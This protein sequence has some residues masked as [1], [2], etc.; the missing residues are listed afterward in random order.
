LKAL[1]KDVMRS[2]LFFIPH[3]IGGIPLFGF[4]I[5][6]GLLVA[7]LIGWI[8]WCLVRKRPASD[9]LGTLPLFAIAAAIVIFVLPGVEQRWPDGTPIGLPIRGY[10]VMV[11]LGLLSGVGLTVLRARQ[12]GIAADNVIGLGFWMM[13][14]G[15]LGARAFYVIQ[16]WEEFDTWGKVFQLTEGGLVIYGGVLGGLIAGAVYCTK[17]RLKIPAMADLITPGFLLG[18]AFGRVGCLLHGCCYGG[19]CA[20]D[21]PS[22]QFAHGSVPYQAQ[23]ATGRL[24]GITT[25][26]RQ[27]PSRIL[28]V[29][30]ESAAA[31]HGIAAGQQLEGVLLDGLPAQKGSNPTA[32][33]QLYVQ[34]I[35]DG[36][37]Y[38]FFPS[39]LPVVSL[40]THPSQVYSAINALL[41]CA[42]LW[43]LQPL[44][45]RDGITF[46]A[47]IALYAV[48]RFVLE[49][50]RSDEAGQ[51]GTSLTIAQ[52]IAVISIGLA[53]AGLIALSRRPPGRC[54]RWEAAAS[55]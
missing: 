48:S 6:M 9:W 28:A 37:K 55:Y 22:L 23:I 49:G 7:A 8:L 29:E 54:W 44:P 40:P 3:E 14:T 30:P 39:A 34:A 5:A 52:W 35:V 24:L 50:V 16:K 45:M 38:D 42:L 10:G 15:I 18:L 31:R 41:L 13:F 2:T 46:L 27:L 20:A 19:V 12:L 36:T 33:P 43:F 1:E 51:L 26:S 11:L 32:P 47:G 17:H 4:G 21:L 25:E 53:V